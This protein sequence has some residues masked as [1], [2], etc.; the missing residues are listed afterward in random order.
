MAKFGIL[1]FQGS[2]FR[3]FLEVFLTFLPTGERF[4][5]FSDP[6]FA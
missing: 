5:L 3:A 4:G 1:D 2:K 6:I